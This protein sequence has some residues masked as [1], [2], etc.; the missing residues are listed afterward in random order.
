ME[1]SPRSSLSRLEVDFFSG[2]NSVVEPYL[3]AGFG[4]PGPCANGIVLL[5]TTGRK[6]GRTINVPLMAMSLGDV[7]V[8]STVRARRSQWIRNVVAYPEVRLWMRGC[9]RK[10]TAFV[11]GDC[12]HAADRARIPL[13][14][15][16]LAAM[17]HPL[18][19]TDDLSFAILMARATD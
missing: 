2:L 17:L 6:S 10:M 7:V 13:R 4:T 15:R 16:A 18:T 8:V 14:V 1:T 3:R 12:A 11:V 9:A 19:S 5:E